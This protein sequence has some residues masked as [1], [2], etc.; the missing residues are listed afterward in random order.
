MGVRISDHLPRGQEG[1]IPGVILREKLGFTKT[2]FNR[3][4]ERERLE[5]S[6]I[7]CKGGG[8][9]LSDDP[10]EILKRARS[11]RR[12]GERHVK[13]AAALETPILEE[14]RK[15]FAREYNAQ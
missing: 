3:Q 2:G 7:F 12:W 10:D 1:A 14:R 6:P 8:Y 4:L 9:Y 15:R 11:L 13:I 5:G